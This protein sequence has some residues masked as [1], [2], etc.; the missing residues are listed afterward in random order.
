MNHTFDEFHLGSAPN[1]IALQAGRKIV[2]PPLLSERNHVSFIYRTS[3]ICHTVLKQF[4]PRRRLMRVIFDDDE[5]VKNRSKNK[6]VVVHQ[7]LIF[8]SSGDIV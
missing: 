4:L 6:N 7:K 5:K 8:P 3:L 2:H 1:I